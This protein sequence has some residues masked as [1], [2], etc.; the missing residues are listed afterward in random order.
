MKLACAERADPAAPVIADRIGFARLTTSAFNGIDL[1]PLRDR[2]MAKV[3]EGTAEAGEGMDL[4]LIIQLL[5]DKATGLAI[6]K[7]VLSFHRL[8]RSPSAVEQP[9][10]RVLALAAAID[11][12][13]NTPIEFLLQDSSFELL[14]LYVVEGT[15]LPD[16]LP[17]HDVAIVIASD[18]EECRA[19]LAANYDVSVEE[20]MTLGP[21]TVRPSYELD[22]A[23]ERMR[24]QNL[25][26]LPVT[27]SDGVLIGI[28]QREDAERAL[29]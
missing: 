1:R 17:A 6:Q 27:R 21:S 15:P 10:L 8:F 7:E 12:G 13:G 9:T 16:P 29:D 4:S 18:S 24:K 20:A 5:G 11:M 22:A 23:V 3:A 2:L 26:S 19:A 28:L 14:T 25:T